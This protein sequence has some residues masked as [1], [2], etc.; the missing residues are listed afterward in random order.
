MKILRGFPFQNEHQEALAAPM[1]HPKVTPNHPRAAQSDP[2]ATKREHFG[3][4]VA[5]FRFMWGR[6]GRIGA[7]K[8]L[9][10]GAGFAP[11]GSTF[12]PWGAI[13]VQGP[14]RAMETTGNH[15]KPAEISPK[16]IQA[17]AQIYLCG[18]S[19]D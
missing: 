5:G 14:V 3:S 15:R 2:R 10:S 11:G 6:S 7:T 13:G 8:G 12:A 1:M 18:K 4:I 17:S 9:L 16:L 19:F